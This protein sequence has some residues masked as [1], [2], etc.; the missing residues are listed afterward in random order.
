MARLQ[1]FGTGLDNSPGSISALLAD[2]A[3]GAAQPLTSTT[4]FRVTGGSGSVYEFRGTGFGSVN[5]SGLPTVGDVTRLVQTTS[6]VT[7]ADYD[8][9]V[10]TTATLLTLIQ[11]VNG[12]LATNTFFGGADL[13]SGSTSSDSLFGY[14]GN[15]TIEGREGL[16]ILVGGTGD[17]T[18]SGGA[19]TDLLA[20]QDGADRL[21][22]DGG[23]DILR[24]GIGADRLVG[25][26][27]W[28]LTAG[29][30]AIFRI[31]QATLGRAPDSGGLR[32]WAEQLAGGQDLQA[33]AAQFI[34]SAEFQSRFGAPDNAGFVQL[35]YNNV[36]GREPDAGGFDFWLGQ[37][38]SGRSVPEVV[39]GFSESAEF[40]S[41]TEL[42]ASTFATYTLNGD[43]DGQVFRLYQTTLGR[44]PDEGGFLFWTDRL[45]AGQ[46][47]SSMAEEFIRSA[48]FQARFSATQNSD[49]IDLLYQNVL[50]RAPDP[51]GFQFYLSELEGGRD[52]GSIVVEFSESA[53]NRSRTL[54]GMDQFIGTSAISLA[55]E[56]SGE[57]GNDELFGG[58]GADLFIFTR[59]AN[60]ADTVVGLDRYDEIALSGFGITN[61][62]TF[63]ERL[64]VEGD[65]VVFSSGGHTIRF[66][67][68]TLD[69]LR[70]VDF[71][72]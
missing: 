8:G 60:D 35:L 47:L 52:R 16:D 26:Y 69:L 19:D 51:G 39:L 48:E 53:E 45:F 64:T 70:E 28:L 7:V 1:G 57:A 18:I 29:E 41:A 50:G 12:S 40:I 68:T 66:V 17:D 2:I 71:F 37:L 38:N 34:S 4:L 36:L 24:G 27:G 72:F 25:D 9:L 31:Y 15:D 43:L 21:L 59:T 56:L 42:T 65:D 11:S 3:N 58:R 54:L 13:I 20:G 44:A 10:L 67:D 5:A 61:E 32:F 49:F 22:G 30:S 33:V 23:A 55:D 63:F 46:T 62:A 6:G 14:N